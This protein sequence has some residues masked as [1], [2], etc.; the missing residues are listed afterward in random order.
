MKDSSAVFGRLAIIVLVALAF[1]FLYAGSVYKTFGEPG[2]PLDDSWIHFVFA[3]NTANGDFFAYNPNKPILGTT[4]PLWVI[5]M[6]PA[7][8]F[9]VRP[10]IWAYIFGFLFLALTGIVTFLFARQFM[11]D[12]FALW[13]AIFVVSA[14]RLLYGAMSGMEVALVA[15]LWILSA[16]LVWRVKTFGKGKFVLAFVLALAVYSR[17]ESYLFT[18]LCL[19]YLF[20]D[21]V[22][23]NGKGEFVA[24]LKNPLITGIIWFVFVF[25]YPILCYLSHHRLFPTTFY[26]K[27]Y[28]AGVHFSEY[29]VKAIGWFVGDN[30]IWGALGFL[31]IVLFFV[32]LRWARENN[33]RPLP[34]IVWLWVVIFLFAEGATVAA[35]WHRARYIMPLIPFWVILAMWLLYVVFE[36]FKLDKDIKLS[37]GNLGGY[38]IKLSLIFLLIIFGLNFERAKKVLVADYI[39]DVGGI[40]DINVAMGEII[41]KVVPEGETVAVNDIGAT[42]YFGKRP[43]FDL[44][45]IISPEVLPI[46]DETGYLGSHVYAQ[47]MLDYLKCRQDIKYMAV[48]PHWFPGMMS[49]KVFEPIY[50]V[51]GIVVGRTEAVERRVNMKILYKFHPELL[52]KCGSSD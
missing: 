11:S 44:L 24:R 3:R 47:K 26:T 5:L 1:C 50:Y 39:P 25:P 49:E 36:R 18:A 4:S 43:I 13:G 22:Q 15:F 51:M 41:N 17:P 20:I 27:R 42:A 16:Y 30:L 2:F 52:G 19:A 8:W 46:I 23:S 21:R 10:E 45:G 33:L 9:G 37:F 35:L 31:A 48:F 6:V 34:T 12:R 32:L 38:T 7:Y 29:I 14:G 28:A 40:R